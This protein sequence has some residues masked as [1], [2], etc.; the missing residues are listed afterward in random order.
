MGPGFFIR[1]RHYIIGLNR[2][3]N[4]RDKLQDQWNWKEFGDGGPDIPWWLCAYGLPSYLGLGSNLVGYYLG[5][6]MTIK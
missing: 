3:P 1:F 5:E 2:L 6:C 4:S